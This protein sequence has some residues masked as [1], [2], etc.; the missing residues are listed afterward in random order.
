MNA[1]HGLLLLNKPAGLSSNQALQRVRHALGAAKGGHTGALDPLATGM[2]PLCFGESTRLAGLLLEAD[3]AYTTTAQ[4]GARSR[5]GDAEGELFDQ[6]PVPVLDAA[7]VEAV[8]ARFRGPIEQIP[9]MYSALKQGGRTLY[10]LARKGIEVERAARPVTIHTLSCT[11]IEGHR[12]QLQVVCS[13]GTYIRTL[14]EDIGQALGCG[15]Y[16]ASLHRDWVAP[17]QGQPM[18]ALNELLALPRERLRERLLPTDAGLQ[19]LPRLQLDAI[20]SENLACGRPL[21]GGGWRQQLTQLPQQPPTANSPPRM[22]RVYAA[23]QR[24]VAVGQL[25]AN[26]LLRIQARFGTGAGEGRQD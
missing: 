3:K 1:V 25:D 16:V 9:P 22:L 7:K 14:V 24:L 12:L 15:A 19:P 10:S 23:D 13:K 20:D 21:L 26:G 18:H 5:T 2:L 4:L 11:A 6:R 8:L 17:F